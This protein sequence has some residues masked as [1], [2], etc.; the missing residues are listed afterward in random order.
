MLKF[1][2]LGGFICFSISIHF[3][4]FWAFCHELYVRMQVRLD[5]Q[6]FYL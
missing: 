3:K 6:L 1:N 2:P 4:N 5:L